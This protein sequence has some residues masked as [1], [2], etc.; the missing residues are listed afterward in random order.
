MGGLSGESRVSSVDIS[1]IKSDPS[2]VLFW[3]ACCFGGDGVNV[4][5]ESC[6]IGGEQNFSNER[7]GPPEFLQILQELTMNWLRIST[8]P[9]DPSLGFERD[10]K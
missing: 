4:Y 5:E 8:V 6:R 9:S 10:F 1:V 3:Q 7:V 2:P